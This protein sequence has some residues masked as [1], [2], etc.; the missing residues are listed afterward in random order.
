MQSIRERNQ[1]LSDQIVSREFQVDAAAELMAGHDVMIS[2]ATGTGK[3]MCY[4]LPVITEM[5][6]TILVVCPLLSLMEDQVKRV[7]S[8]QGFAC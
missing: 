1:T 4:Q 8:P 2:T 5:A 7:N 3:T 6:K